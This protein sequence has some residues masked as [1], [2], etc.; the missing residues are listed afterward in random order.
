[1]ADTPTPSYMTDFGAYLGTFPYYSHSVTRQN[2]KE[3][4]QLR[5]QQQRQQHQY[6]NEEEE[7]DKK[8]PFKQK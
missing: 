5:W 8:K 2:R 7:E 3:N 1:M 6:N 4:C